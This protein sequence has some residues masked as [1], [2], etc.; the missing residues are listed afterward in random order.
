[1][2]RIVKALVVNMTLVVLAYAQSP[3]SNSTAKMTDKDF[4]AQLES[5]VDKAALEDSFSGA[6]LVAKDGKVIFEKAVGFANTGTNSPTK[7]PPDSTWVQ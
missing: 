4:A 7:S 1:M 2:K 6:A 3:Q 5:L